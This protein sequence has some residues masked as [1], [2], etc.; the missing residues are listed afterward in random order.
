V[1][2]PDPCAV[3]DPPAVKTNVPVSIGQVTVP[4]GEPVYSTTQDPFHVPLPL[5]VRLPLPP[6]I[7]S[8][9]MRTVHVSVPAVGVLLPVQAQMT[10]ANPNAIF[11]ENL[12]AALLLL[13]HGTSGQGKQLPLLLRLTGMPL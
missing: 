12:I 1:A 8:P 4:D 2:V 10:D 3:N 9:E 11:A 6:L 13:V 5:N 7:E